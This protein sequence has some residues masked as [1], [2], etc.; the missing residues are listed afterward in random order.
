MRTRRRASL[1][2]MLFAQ[3]HTGFYQ[4]YLSEWP[5]ICY[6]AETPAGKVMGYV[7]GKAEGKGENWHGHVTAVTVA[8]EFRR[9]GLG[10]K[11]MSLLEDVSEKVYDAYFV[12]LYVRAS[13]EV[14]IGMYKRF[15]YTVY[16][17][18]I[19]YYRCVI[20]R[21]FVCVFFVTT[22]RSS[23]GPEEDAFDMR[24]ALREFCCAVVCCNVLMH[25]RQ[26]RDK[27]R[28]SI[29]P[30]ERPVSPSEIYE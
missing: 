25:C 21:D 30:M 8:P 4:C 15:G 11:L 9:L 18:V 16:R 7:L 19:N 10:R 12:D 20:L 13:N 26:A 3:Y 22:W 6:V 23:G 28:A 1:T 24:R 17:R 2:R 5:D 14:A 29:V 27:E